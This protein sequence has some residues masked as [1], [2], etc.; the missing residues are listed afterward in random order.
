MYNE[1]C[2]GMNIDYWNYQYLIRKNVNLKKKVLP[3]LIAVWH[4]ILVF[5]L[6]WRIT[7]S[8]PFRENVYVEFRCCK[9]SLNV[10][11]NSLLCEHD[12][13]VGNKIAALIPS[14]T[15]FSNYDVVC[16]ETVVLTGQ[17]AYT[18][19]FSSI[20]NWELNLGVKVNEM[21][22]LMS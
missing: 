10:Q 2:H 1:K 18:Q 13:N 7:E 21:K 14:L 20:R 6:F 9:M 19:R 4:C 17:T 8:L 12:P 3:F 15:M 16:V 5:A 11:M 22:T